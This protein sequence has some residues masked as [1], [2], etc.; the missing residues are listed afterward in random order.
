VRLFP[1]TDDDGIDV[2]VNASHFSGYFTARNTVTLYFTSQNTRRC[3]GFSKTATASEQTKKKTL[4]HC[5]CFHWGLS[6]SYIK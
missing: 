3:S 6:G 2:H 1:V 4:P 5:W